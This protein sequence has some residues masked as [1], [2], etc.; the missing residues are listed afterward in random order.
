MS[1]RTLRILF[2]A[3]SPNLLAESGCWVT[4]LDLSALRL[5]MDMKIFRARN[6]TY[7]NGQ[8]FS[9]IRFAKRM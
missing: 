9:F 4:G 2:L 7:K 5:P 1:S 8:R 6:P 3:G